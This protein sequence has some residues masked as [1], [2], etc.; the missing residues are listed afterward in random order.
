[1]RARS[2]LL[3]TTAVALTA[4]VVG[5][6]AT[7][8]GAPDAAS[9]APPVVAIPRAMTAP[10][11]PRGMPGAALEGLS[12]RIEQATQ[13]AAATGATISVAVLDR[14]NHQLLSNGSDQLV[15]I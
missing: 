12:A 1:M 10:Q 7:V 4:V 11:P 15:A 9:D 14:A 6:Q 13:D 8:Y 5:L 3:I 2:L